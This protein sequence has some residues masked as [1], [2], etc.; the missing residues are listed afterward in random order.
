MINVKGKWKIK[1]ALTMNDQFEQIW[2][3]VEEMAA[4]PE[5]D[6]FDLQMYESIID[7]GDD[8]IVRTAVKVP[9]DM[10]QEEIDA[11]IASGEC[12]LYAPG[13]MTVEKREWKE[14]DGKLFFKSEV[15]G[16]I[17]GEELDPWTEIIPL[18]DGIEYGT[19]RLVRA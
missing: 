4:D 16:D 11:A 5:V 17:L 9:E 18:Q 13:Y 8:G 12:E 10:P 15:E 14:E 19:F 1:S 6:P 3:T 7:F 2:K